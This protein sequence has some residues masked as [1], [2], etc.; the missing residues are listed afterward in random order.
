MTPGSSSLIF[1]KTGDTASIPDFIES[2]YCWLAEDRLCGLILS[3]VHQRRGYA[4][5]RSTSEDAALRGGALGQSCCGTARTNH[6]RWQPDRFIKGTSMSRPTRCLPVH[7]G[8][9]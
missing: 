9:A 7:P 1:Q 2:V 4:T 3:V 6:P 8:L 5:H